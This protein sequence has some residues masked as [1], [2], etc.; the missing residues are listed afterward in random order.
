MERIV[1]YDTN[2]ETA[3]PLRLLAQQGDSEPHVRVA[4]M[5]PLP[6]QEAFAVWDSLPRNT[7][8]PSLVVMYLPSL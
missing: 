6:A 3:S 1:W 2:M 7:I 8:P 5:S 4:G